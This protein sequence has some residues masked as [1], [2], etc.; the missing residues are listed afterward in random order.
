MSILG[1]VQRAAAALMFTL[2]IVVA[3][4]S[5]SS[6]AFAIPSPELVVGSFVSISQLLALMSAVLG[7]GAAYATMR[8]RKRGG[9]GAM[10]RGL[11]YIAAG[12]FAA[13]TLSIVANIWQYVAQNNERQ[14][15][16]ES[17]LLRP[18][19]AP[20]GLP[21]DLGAK[22]ITFTQQLKHPLRISTE[23]TEKLLAAHNRGEADQ[24][25]FLDVRENAE[26]SMGSLKGATIVR[27]PDLK[28]ANLDLTGKKVIL[29]CHN[30]N[31][32]SE[33]AEVMAKQGIDAKFVVG[34]LEKWVVEG[35]DMDGLSARDLASLRA[36][37]DYRN[38]NTLLDTAQV[39][40]LVDREKATLVDIR[41]PTDFA[42]S[43]IDGAINLSLRRMP[44]EVMNEHIAKLPKRPIVLPCYDRSG[45]FFAEVLGHELTKAGH[46]VRGRYTLPWEY[47]VERARPPYV[48]TWIAEN[49]KGVFAKS[50]YYVAGA[51]S[52]V[53]RWTGVVAVIAL[54][55]LIS[56]LFVLPFSLKSERDQIR[57]RAAADEL[58]SLKAR[59]K[60]D[61]VRRTDAVRGFYKRH[62]IT[63]A[64]NL[65]A[66]AFLPVMAVALTA[67]QDLATQTD[68]AFLWTPGL[69]YRDP[70]FVLPLVFGV[71][72]TLY[73]D[74]AFAS[75]A[76]S[77][78][79]IWIAVL[80]LMTA[81]GRLF[82]AG[83]DVY[84]IVSATLLLVQRLY[85]SGRFVQLWQAWRGSRTPQGI[86][87]FEDVE[88]LENC[89][90]K[91][92]RLARMR[93]AGMPVP[94]GVV[95][96]PAFM[97]RLAGMAASKRT[98]E[99]S[100]IWRRLGK[101][102]LAVR[103]SGA[104]EDGAGRS[105]AGV[106]ESVIDVDRDGLDA[107]ITRVQA[108]FDAARV[109][110]YGFSAGAGNILIQRMVDAEYSGV[111]FTRDPSAGGLAMLEMVQ[112][113]A[114]NL[115]S[116]T[117]RPL[118]F[119]FGRV[120]KKMFGKDAA[121]IDL[122]P[123]LQMGDVAERLFGG[124]QD[125]EWA[126]REGRFQLVQ[127][128]DI[129]RPIAGDA[130]MAAMQNDL[131]R[132]VELAK[133]A[134]GDQI[135]FA[136]NELS[137]ML[138]R[139]TP[140]SLSLMESLWAAGGSVDLAAR[141]LGLR[142]RVEEGSTYL[143]TILG[144]LY[145]NK[146]EEQARALVISALA[147]RRL[148]RAADRIERD[149]REQFL[150]QFMDETRLLKV[151]DFEKLSTADLVAEIKRLHDRFVFDTHVA[152]DVVN[153]AAGLYLDRA[154]KVLSAAAIDP[155]SLL[156][157]IPET[158][159]ARALAEVNAE[160]AKSRRWLLLKHFGHRA[161]L[162][163]E[164]A[165]PRY[166]EDINTLNRM[167]AGRGVAGHP[168]YQ[169]TPALSK[170]QARIVDIA[171][172]FQALKEDAKHHSLSELA[173]LRRA[174][175]ALDR[176]FGLDG[177]AFNLRFD[178]LLSLNGKNAAAM[179]ELARN[180]QDEAQ[181]LRHSPSLPS[182]LLAHDLEAASAGDASEM[183]AM[184]DAIRGTRVS[185]SRVVEARAHV[186]SEEDAEHGNS[187]EG[188]RDGDIIVAP[189]INPAWLPYFSRAGGFVSEVGGWLSH[190][191]ILAR[192]YDVTMI[193]GTEGIGRI[194]N[195]ARLRLNLDGRVEI[196]TADM[197][198][199]Q[200]AA[201]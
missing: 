50:A 52:A 155:S 133:G 13:M 93:A 4:L 183:H 140:L 101:V 36:I 157:H 188:F 191:A 72:I 123:L 26:Q 151:V 110:S 61:P 12:L 200:V 138:P 39:K 83:A 19:H 42:A 112:G 65:L 178:E 41:Y 139:P 173:V 150:P 201:A 175:M 1:C 88:R 76:K 95:L 120:T 9:S 8:A 96:T 174:V 103:S 153:I 149:F 59:F 38:R 126:Y 156:G 134:Q 80:P 159:E 119:R 45:C 66:L 197:M 56:R 90:N 113:T 98:Q 68:G 27:F 84:L 171:R 77:R 195:G 152:V 115:V 184:S 137:E 154:R 18:F 177:R 46:D 78:A 32:S 94:D 164:L 86:I 58:E 100:W 25:V 124:P 127:S 54:L 15:R 49:N 106:F 34:G 107:A 146:R 57:G 73:V 22:E 176:R 6:Q 33:T 162:D 37:P 47:F 199:G 16:L 144:R 130:D 79:L 67:V 24:Y 142:Y 192:E 170:A 169:G 11:I 99:L 104:A 196:V 122:G 166:A 10:S 161:V 125:M 135:V 181:R 17:T 7:G 186:I 63:P 87:A 160:S 182:I 172:R 14:A 168:G 2:A 30:G 62:G 118:S 53:S 20:A 85:V 81:T 132:A 158:H 3:Y 43:H 143:V 40:A 129:T 141:E 91:A 194:A 69:G 28:K 128:R 35:R 187:M 31:R 92:Y 51:M 111:L 198:L 60:D 179:R 180:R 74:L 190:P 71:L 48:E 55:A 102:K 44:T 189:M 64:R 114:E 147:A 167:V 145:V 97:A 109:S 185:G 75:S 121:P 117:V 136:K 5:G 163:Y 105:F 193:V 165:E 89:G 70:W 23:E 116:G 21:A 148:V 82:S 108:S 131:A 29:F